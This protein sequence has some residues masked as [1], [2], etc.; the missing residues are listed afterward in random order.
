M[1]STI[2]ISNKRMLITLAFLSAFTPLS[3]DLYLPALP[4]MVEVFGTSAA[5]INMTLSLFFVSLSA[6]MLFFGPIS[7]KFGRR[8]VL[9]FGL[10][11]YTLAS[12]ACALSESAST[13]IIARI[14][15]AF[16]GGAATTIA[17]AIAKDLY[18]GEERARMLATIL[19]MVIIAPI[20]A[21]LLGALVLQFASWR[22]IFVLL[23][24]A[25][26]IA[27]I[28]VLPLQEPLTELYEGSTIRSIGRLFVVLK[29]P[30][31][32]ML[33]ILFSTLSL[34][35]M[36]YI[37]ASSYIYINNFGLGEGAF[38]FYFAINSIAAMAGP[39]IYIRI[40]KRLG[41][42][43]IITISFIA[44]CLS[45]ILV[46]TIGHLAPYA[47]AL[48]LMPATLATTAMRSPS[49]NITL[50]Q[51]E[52]DAGSSSALINFLGM[53]LGGAGVSA[54]FLPGDDLILSIGAMQLLIGI[55]GGTLWLLVKNDKIVALKKVI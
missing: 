12:A 44:I 35:F 45:G 29:N 9:F 10:I 49:I 46:A 15:Q 1:T 53:L 43:K 16:G 34:P 17:T 23:T 6:G 48:C 2:N 20:V 19:A 8:P 14:F 40:S 47:F 50:E 41:S 26:V 38:S 13:L 36:G 27:F 11:L 28:L 39:M 18:S 3:I 42:Y 54:V 55:G 22:A 25:G 7:D 37:A 21:P 33:L 24:A 4:Q 5:K 32:S 31:F 51:H 30:S 52:G